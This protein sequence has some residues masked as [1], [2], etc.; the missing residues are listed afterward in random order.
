MPSYNNYSNTDSSFRSEAQYVTKYNK[1]F[2]NLY[3]QLV[4]QFHL[5]FTVLFIISVESCLTVQPM[6]KG[7]HILN[8]SDAEDMM[9]DDE[10]K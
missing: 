7:D 9:N 3:L 1:L 5:D 10:L 4:C 2:N 6:P 8:F